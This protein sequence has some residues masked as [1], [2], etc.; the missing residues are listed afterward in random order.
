MKK[1]CKLLIKFICAPFLLYTYNL[2]A[3]PLNMMIPI[4]IY[5]I[6]FVGLFGIPAML[7][8][9]LVLLFLKR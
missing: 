8:I 4:N 2:I 7:L 1:L 9:I 3:A 5:T 6:C